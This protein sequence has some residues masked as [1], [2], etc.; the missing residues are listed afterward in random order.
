VF[1]ANNTF[2]GSTSQASIVK[3]TPHGAQSTFATFSGNLKAEGLVFDR[4]GNLFVAVIGQTSPPY[5]TTI[6]KFAPNGMQRRFGSVPGWVLGDLVFDDAGNLFAGDAYFAYIYK[7]APNGSRSV[8]ADPSAFGSDQFPAGLA[9]DSLGN[10]FV[11]TQAEFPAGN[12]VILKF[13]PTGVESIFATDLDWPN[14]L[15]FDRNGNLFVAEIGE[16]APPGNVL[17]FTP[18]G[19]KTVFAQGLATPIFLTFQP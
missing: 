1:V 7:F 8:F 9:F 10:L 13:T 16:F 17:S 6:Y 12:D 14:S 15:C 18:Q 3:I 19:N 11:S 5:P 4:V 2:D